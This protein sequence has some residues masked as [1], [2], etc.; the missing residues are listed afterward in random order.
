MATMVMQSLGCDVAAINTVQ[1]SNHLGYGQVK[2][3]HASSSEIIEIWKG[4][5]DLHLDDF[6]ILLSGYLPDPQSVDAMAVIG[7]ELRAKSKKSPGRFFWI[8][9]PIM[10]DNGKLYVSES[11]VPAYKSV[12]QNTDLILPNHFEAETLSGVKIDDEDTLKLAISIFHSRFAIPHILIT[13]LVLKH[14][15]EESS[16]LYVAGSSMT[17]SKTPRIFIIKIPR[18]DCQ[19]SGTGDMFGALILVRLREAVHKSPGL[20]NAPN[21]LSNDDVPSVE[22]PLAKAAEKVAASIH[23]ILC[24]SKA[25]QDVETATYQKKIGSENETPDGKTESKRQRWTKAK[26]AEVQ[27]VRNLQVLKEPAET[28]KADPL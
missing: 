7:Q 15:D 11:M 27:I 9:D 14:R 16:F 25:R 6:Q 3:T 5:Q 1:F 22:L 17:S 20:E 23:E 13:S 19:F 24:R 8:V 26:A 21:W 2:G 10:G 4:L 12:L 28:F 18:I